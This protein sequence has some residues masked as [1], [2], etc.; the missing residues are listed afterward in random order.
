MTVN[1]KKTICVFCGSSFGKEASYSQAATELGRLLAAK[2]YGLVYGGGTTGLMGLI[3]KS[4]ASQGGYVH[5]IIPDALVSKERT[6]SIDEINEKIQSDVDNHKGETPLDDSYGRTTIVSDMHTRKRMMGMEANGGFVAM[7]GGFGTLEEIMEVTTW[8]QLGIHQKPVVLFNVD[9]FY[10]DFIKF[11]NKA[12]EA[13]FI[14][15]NN[16]NIVAVASTPEEVIEKLDNYVVPDGRFNL[17][18]KNH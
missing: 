3:A 13:G 18:W 4:V 15:K 17:T 12:V 14:S 1:P 5:G 11:L 10:D 7:P 16:S 9:G 2:D 6:S 8:S